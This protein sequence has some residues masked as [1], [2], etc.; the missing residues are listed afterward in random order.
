MPSSLKINFPKSW[1][2][3]CTS[4]KG[5]IIKFFEHSFVWLTIKNILLKLK[6]FYN[7]MF[8]IQDS[9]KM[10]L[11]CKFKIISTFTSKVQTN[12]IIINV[13]FF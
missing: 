8:W 4:N 7:T 13:F 12:N 9:S 1:L 5:G 6:F 3:N 2:K 10:L 11:K